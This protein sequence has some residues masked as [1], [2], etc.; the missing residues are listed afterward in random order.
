LDRTSPGFTEENEED[1]RFGSNLLQGTASKQE[2]SEF[3]TF[4]FDEAEAS[5]ESPTTMPSNQFHYVMTVNN[6]KLA[7][8]PYYKKLM[9]N[10][11][12]PQFCE[13]MDV[14][15]GQVITYSDMPKKL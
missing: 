12:E 15:Y 6:S 5:E 8:R 3:N 13:F 9:R 14:T 10:Y 4:V 2:T 7:R 1:L 11:F